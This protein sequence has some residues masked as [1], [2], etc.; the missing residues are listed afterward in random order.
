MISNAGALKG[1]A[2]RPMAPEL[3]AVPPY[4]GSAPFTGRADDLARLD[5]WARSP[6]RSWLWRR[7]AALASLLLPGNGPAIERLR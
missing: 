6:I 5:E 3:A 4:V 7:S 2:G 1:S